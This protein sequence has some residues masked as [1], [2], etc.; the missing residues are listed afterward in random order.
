MMLVPFR[1]TEDELTVL[2]AALLRFEETLG[3]LVV[4]ADGDQCVAPADPAAAELFE[5]C[6][7]LR[8]VLAGARAR[9]LAR[10]AAVPGGAGRRFGWSS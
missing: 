4:A 1:F 8:G 3:D 6:R 9:E 7:R 10:R 2:S 5:T